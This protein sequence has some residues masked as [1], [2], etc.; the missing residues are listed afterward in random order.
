MSGIMY[1]GN[2]MVSPVIMS[3][4]FNVDSSA[5]LG[6]V[7]ENGV[8]VASQE[9]INAVFNGVKDLEDR[10]LANKFTNNKFIKS[11]NFPDLEKLS[12]PRSLY[13]C[14]SGSS[15]ESLN[16]GKLE[17]ITSLD[18]GV[19]YNGALAFC[20]NSTKSIRSI[21]FQ[22]L[23]T[24]DMYDA[25]YNFATSSGIEEANFPLLRFAGNSTF[26]GAFYDSLL[27]SI[28]LES[29]EVA[30]NRCFYYCCSETPLES[31]SFNKLYS[32]GKQCFLYCFSDCENLKH[33]YF[34]SL[35]ANSFG[36][37]NSCFSGMLDGSEDV[38]VHFPVGLDTTIG[39]WTAVLSGFGGVNTTILYDLPVCYSNISVVGTNDY[40]T[41]VNGSVAVNPVSSGI[42][43]TDYFVCDN[44]N[45]RVFF[46]KLT[47]LDPNETKTY[48]ADVNLATDKITISTGVSG[49]NVHVFYDGK[50]IPLTSDY[51]GN[52]YFYTMTS[53]KDFSYI[54][55]ETEHTKELEGR[56]TTVGTDL[57]IQVTLKP[58]EWESFVRPNLTDDGEMGVDNFA[59]SASYN[60][61]SYKPYKAVDGIWSNTDNY[62]YSDYESPAF[63]YFYSKKPLKLKELSFIYPR[64][65]Y[66]AKKIVVE[67]S[68]DYE[69]WVILGTYD[70]ESS[71][72]ADLNVD[73]DIPYNYF[74]ITFYPFWYSFMRVCELY[75]T[76]LE[77]K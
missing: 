8:L 41:Y 61:S 56:F 4:T 47:E 73:S 74:K 27:N 52:Y 1:L 68:N 13:S 66:S 76:A 51:N 53:E 15:I 29:L 7:D 48:I 38:V 30:G 42:Y 45:Y 46:G 72:R 40:T 70:L 54:I 2:Q 17:T 37:N 63:Y 33:L 69:N 32:V 20:L 50:A 23:K 62:W 3:K 43:D 19:E 36:G 18:T 34:Y 9:P 49:L 59:V 10:A 16:F 35:N 44:T 77:Y 55:E 57:D 67:G 5:F 11:A 22:K 71:Y 25:F 75:I 26:N 28:C 58:K 12:N 21:E 24:V 6:T 65:D 31:V 64:N 14:F 39:D 60:G